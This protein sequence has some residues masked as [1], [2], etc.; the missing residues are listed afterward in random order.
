[1][2]AFF[3]G[4]RMTKNFLPPGKWSRK[5]DRCQGCGTTTEEHCA[6]GYCIPCYNRFVCTPDVYNKYPSR[7]RESRKEADK[8]YEQ[9]HKDHTRKNEKQC[10]Y[11]KNNPE[12]TSCRAATRKAIRSGI[13]IRPDNC[14]K[15]GRSDMKIQAHHYMG[16]NH[17]LDI[18]WLCIYCHRDAD[19][20]MKK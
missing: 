12:K 18:E 15:C 1:M 16:Y 19:R 7:S 13:L 9:R 10:L 14:S 5:Y 8:R 3:T 4:E 11:R 6:K 17:P 2:V 20:L